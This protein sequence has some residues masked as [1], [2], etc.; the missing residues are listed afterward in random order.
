MRPEFWK[1]AGEVLGR[2]PGISYIFI[3]FLCLWAASALRVPLFT[4]G[5]LIAG[6]FVSL[7]IL[8]AR[9][10]SDVRLQLIV[11]GSYGMRVILSLALYFISVWQIPIFSSIQAG[12]GFWKFSL[13]S[14]YYHDFAT[15]IVRAW[16]QGIELPDQFGIEYYLVIGGIYRVLGVHPLYPVFVNI[17][18]A[19]VDGILAYLIGK[20]L[21][22]EKAGITAALLVCFWPSFL[23]WSTQILKDSLVL[24]LSLFVVQ[25]LLTIIAPGKIRA[26]LYMMQY[27]QYGVQWILLFMAVLLLYRFRYYTGFAILLSVLFLLPPVAFFCLARGQVV[28]ALKLVGVTCLITVAVAS[29]STL[30]PRRLFSARHPGIGH[31]RLG[32]QHKEQGEIDKAVGEFQAAISINPKYAPPYL[33]LAEVK[34]SQGK[35]VESASLYRE[36]LRLETE[37][38]GESSSVG[39]PVDATG[40]YPQ[41]PSPFSAAVPGVRDVRDLS[42][43]SLSG[44]HE[45]IR[46]IA[47]R[48]SLE[49]LSRTRTGF[50]SGG[51]NTVVDIEIRDFKFPSLFR[52]IPGLIV[53][54][55]F[56]PFPWQWFEV[57]RS[58][59]VLRLLSGFEM[60]LFYFLFPAFLFSAWQ[61]I[62]RGQVLRVL[63]IL[64]FL[65]SIFSV[66]LAVANLGTLFRLR[67]QALILLLILI[68]L[69]NPLEFYK[70]I[71]RKIFK[72]GI[73]ERYR[74]GRL[75]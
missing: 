53:I 7:L 44:L 1:R 22:G 20:R 38:L 48:L 54:G 6:G 65:L 46:N 73:S 3:F 11:L 50:I 58:T 27:M 37:R 67:F 9:I 62:R 21:S 31:Y 42:A 10:A 61:S 41:S 64:F 74:K 12:N 30:E 16:Q 45:G 35:L 75:P 26:R 5:L 39:S 23:A 17:W 40:P 4:I 33:A 70:R 24:F 71:W 25:L 60:L 52:D 18:L 57:G 69:E 51:G 43:S 8:S 14:T 13:D 32:V 2:L 15:I 29:G 59:N 34:Q 28:R 36:Y 47:E 68:S 49:W 66:S 56:S 63:L 55:V 72:D 19:S